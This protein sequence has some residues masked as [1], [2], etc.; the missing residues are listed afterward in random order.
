VVAVRG[1]GRGGCCHNG[2][3]I[4]TATTSPP[5][6]AASPTLP[7]PPAPAAPAPEAVARRRPA[8][9]PGCRT[10]AGSKGTGSSLGP[11]ASPTPSA[12]GGPSGEIWA[13]GALP[14]PRLPL[15][16]PWPRVQHKGKPQSENVST[17]TAVRGGRVRVGG[18]GRGGA[19]RG[20]GANAPPCPTKPVGVHNHQPLNRGQ[21]PTPPHVPPCP[22]GT[23]MGSGGVWG[24]THRARSGWAKGGA[25]LTARASRGS[26]VTSGAI[27]AT[28][29]K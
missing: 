1:G 11:A 2:Q 19:G 3:G 23:P 17:S 10:G 22:K 27:S 20:G 16:G 25:A 5:L 7:L 18:G 28:G 21:R 12:N 14:P 9:A 26:N 29:S 8:L 6:A 15:R 13:L 4:S 24:G